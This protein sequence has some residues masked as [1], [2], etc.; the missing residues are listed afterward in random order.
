M[1]QTLNKSEALIA[2]IHGKKIRLNYFEPNEY[3]VY[4]NG[5]FRD[6]NNIPEDMNDYTEQS[7]WFEHVMPTKHAKD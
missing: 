4:N 6:E 7:G 3:F 1:K 5:M 2:M